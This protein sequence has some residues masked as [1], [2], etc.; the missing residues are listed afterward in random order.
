MS[1]VDLAILAILLVSMLVSLLR[2]F[3]RETF[4]LV[5]WVVAATA[6]FRFSGDLASWFQGWV[7]VPSLRA[8]IA[9]AAVFVLVLVVGGL[10]G[11]LLGKLVEKSGLSPTDRMLGALFG[12]ARGLVIVVMAVL[13]A[14]FTPFPN[15]PWWDD[16]RLLPG[17]E[18]M[19]DRASTLLPDSLRELLPMP[20]DQR[21]MALSEH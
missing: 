19:A 21:R 15:D 6:G 8:L 18:Q 11:W 4:S 12:L 1:G 17:F 10:F 13:L 16:S 5:V 20:D 2:G 7:S 14:R 9:F 3:I